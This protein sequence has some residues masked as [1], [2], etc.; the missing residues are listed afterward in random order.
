MTQEIR[1]VGI[2]KKLFA[3]GLVVAVLCATLVSVLLTTQ[4]QLARGPK[5]D[6]GDQ[7]EAG[8]QGNKGD[9][10]RDGRE[11]VFAHWDVQWR[12]MTGTGQW[13]AVVGSSTLPATFYYDWGYGNVFDIYS[14]YIGFYTAT[15]QVKMQ[16]NG[17]VTFT[18]G[19]D[20]GV[21]FW[22]DGV[23]K[24][25][26][27]GPHTYRTKSITINDLSQGFH[28]LAL[29]YKETYGSASLSFGCDLD[30]IMWYA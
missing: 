10:G 19:A 24:I 9:P 27:S 2:S 16:R 17:P 20:D 15:M 21:V 4:T 29:D 23:M 5:G 30:L 18:V 11:V 1:S 3:A 25:D 12:T 28:T 22:I 6:K 26:N 13:A 14:D 8:P 7:G